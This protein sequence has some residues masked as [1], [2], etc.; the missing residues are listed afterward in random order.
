M[1]IAWSKFLLLKGNIEKK[2]VRISNWSWWKF[3]QRELDKDH[4][5]VLYGQ[6]NFY[7][8]TGV[9]EERMFVV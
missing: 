6:I 7:S 2:E 9:T 5:L 1:F 3:E 4:R 8:E